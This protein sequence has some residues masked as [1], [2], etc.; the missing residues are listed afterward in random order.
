VLAE[1][2]QVVPGAGAAHPESNCSL[3]HKNLQFDM[4][5]ILLNLNHVLV[6]TL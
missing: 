2:D 3:Q 1:L 6:L 4:L 5:R